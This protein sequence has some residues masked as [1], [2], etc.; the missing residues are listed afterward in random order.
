M[1]QQVR[2]ATRRTTPVQHG[3]SSFQFALQS[4]SYYDGRPGLITTEHT[5]A[6][7]PVMNYREGAARARVMPKSGHHGPRNE[8]DCQ[9]DDQNP[10]LEE[11]P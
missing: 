6:T 5:L 2:R 10:G 1:P 8:N 11:V 3:S 7:S 9:H 4:F